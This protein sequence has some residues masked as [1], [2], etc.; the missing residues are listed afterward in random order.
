[1]TAPQ[2]RIHCTIDTSQLEQI[3]GKA[4]DLRPFFIEELQPLVTEFLTR[5]FDTGGAFGGAP[6]SPLAEATLALRKRPGHGRG[7]IGRDTGRMWASWVKSVGATA[8][9]GGVLK[10]TKDRYERGSS[11]KQSLFFHYGIESVTKPVQIEDKSGG[12]RWIFVRRK[13]PKRIPPRYIV[14]DVL[15]AEFLDTVNL[16]VKAYFLGNKNP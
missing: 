6:W 10:I 9:P 7:G 12:A 1:M 5:R 15:P 2:Q 13:V 11:L 3:D 14:P 8:A 16:R 4:A